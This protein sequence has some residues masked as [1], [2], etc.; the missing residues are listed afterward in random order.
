MNLWKV[1]NMS[2]AR[3]LFFTI[4]VI[5]IVFLLFNSCSVPN[6]MHRFS[7]K[8]ICVEDSCE[9]STI[10]I[11]QKDNYDLAF[12][13]FS[14]RGNIFS[15]KKL[16][17][18]INHIEKE[19]KN[20]DGIMLLI[21]AH[22]WRHNASNVES[23]NVR[24]FRKLLKI[25]S[26]NK[27]SKRKTIGVYIGWRGLT[28]NTE[29]FKTLTYWGR[30]NVARQVGNGGVSEL[31]LRLNK[32][33]NKRN[34]KNI[35]VISGHSFG[36]AVILASIK[37][38]LLDRVINIKESNPEFCD[39]KN[40]FK[41]VCSGKCYKT[42]GFG[43]G[44]ILLNPAVEANEL[45]QIKELVTKERCYSREQPKLLHIL[46]SSSDKANKYAFQI[47][48]LLG[49]S[50]RNSEIKLP[51][52][53]F[54]GDTDSKKNIELNEFNLDTKTV[55]NYSPFITG[56]SVSREVLSNDKMKKCKD[57]KGSFNE[58]YIPCFGEG[59]CVSDKI[60]NFPSSPYE[61]VSIVY[62]NSPFINSH[63]DVFNE[64]VVA[65]MASAI[66]ENQYKRSK[67]LPESLVLSKN[68]FGKRGNPLKFNFNKCNNFFRDLYVEDFC[69]EFN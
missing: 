24:K 48:Q 23:G 62:T 55:G 15:R 41:E 50:L 57:R 31:L 60:K 18:V 16:D 8:K 34:N 22:G 52:K 63:T 35:F 30:K 2:K 64:N 39:T 47:G 29:P 7:E 42:E 40:N 11:H 20:K 46:S 27:I 36:A 19:E 3:K 65:Y 59:K 61:P 54:I 38:I 67:I 69:R 21:Y 53:I 56:K 28:S 26:K 6:K 13:E 14:E 5:P 68:C 66:I 1:F 32:I 51:R 10:E 45:L 37:G 33:T 9:N 43:D 49:V 4:L 44:I 12:V 17:D 58:N 25:V